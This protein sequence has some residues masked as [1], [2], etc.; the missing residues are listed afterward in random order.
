[1]TNM[2]GIKF[3]GGKP[4]NNDKGMSNFEIIEKAHKLKLPNFKYY[5]RDEIPKHCTSEKECGII[6]LDSS[7]NSGTHHCAYWKNNGNHYYFDSYGLDPPKEMVRY[8]DWMLINTYQ[9][10]QFNDSNCSEWCLYVL[11]ELNKGKEFTDIILDIIND[12]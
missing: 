8:L 4:Y 1:M 10:Q 9:I 5:M 3:V 2:L 12:R 7:K 6:N 11:N